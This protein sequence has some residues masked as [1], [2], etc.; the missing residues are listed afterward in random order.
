M[1]RLIDR[2][3]PVVMVRMAYAAFAIDYSF[4]VHLPNKPKILLFN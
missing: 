4:V 1:T 2:M 3:Q